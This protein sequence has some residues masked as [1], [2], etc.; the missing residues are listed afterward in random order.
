[1]IGL[2]LGLIAVWMWFVLVYTYTD[3][4]VIVVWFIAPILL[5]LGIL[6]GTLQGM[7]DKLHDLLLGVADYVSDYERSIYKKQLKGNK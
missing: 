1:M 2:I 3:E 4:A 5:P 6:L 7:L